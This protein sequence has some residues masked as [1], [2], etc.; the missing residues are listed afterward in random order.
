V[1]ADLTPHQ[2]LSLA[3]LLVCCIA[4]VVSSVTEDR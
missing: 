4:F 1:T 2:W 3:I